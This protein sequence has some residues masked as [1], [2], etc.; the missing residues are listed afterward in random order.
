MP[1]ENALRCLFYLSL[2]LAYFAFS[3]SL[4]KLS[5]WLF[6][7]ITTTTAVL[8]ACWS[9]R[10][11][12]LCPSMTSL[13]RRYAELKYNDKIGERTQAAVASLNGLFSPC[14]EDPKLTD[15]VL[16]GQSVDWLYTVYA[17]IYISQN[18]VIGHAT[19]VAFIDFYVELKLYLTLLSKTYL[20]LDRPDA[21]NIVIF[22]DEVPY[23]RQKFE[24]LKLYQTAQSLPDPK[25]GEISLLS[26][27]NRANAAII[28]YEDIL[29]P[30]A[31]LRA[32]SRFTLL[33]ELG[34]K[35]HD[36]ITGL[37]D[38]R[39]NGCRITRVLGSQQPTF[40][41]FHVLKSMMMFQFLGK[42]EK[43]PVPKYFPN[44]DSLLDC[45][46]V[47]NIEILEEAE[48]SQKRIS[49][50][51]PKG[52]D[53]LGLLSMLHGTNIFEVLYGQGYEERFSRHPM[54]MMFN[55]NAECYEFKMAYQDDVAHYVQTG[56]N[57]Y[58]FNYAEVCD[59]TGDTVLSSTFHDARHLADSLIQRFSTNFPNSTGFTLGFHGTS[60]GGMY[61]IKTATHVASVHPRSLLSFALFQKTFG[62]LYN[63]AW[64]RMGWIGQVFSI[65]FGSSVDVYEDYTSLDIP[66]TAV[67]DVND[68]IIP[69]NLSLSAHVAHR[70]MKDN[71]GDFAKAFYEVAALYRNSEMALVR[72]NEADRVYAAFYAL[73]S[74]GIHLGVQ[75]ALVRDDWHKDKTYLAL[76]LARMVTF[77]SL[78]ANPTVTMRP[79]PLRIRHLWM[80]LSQCRVGGFV[81]GE[82][83]A[84]RYLEMPS[85]IALLFNMFFK[86]RAALNVKTPLQ[87]TAVTRE[88]PTYVPA[89]PDG[90]PGWKVVEP[91]ADDDQ[92]A[93]RYFVFWPRNKSR[94]TANI[95]DCTS[96]TA[97]KVLQ[98]DLAFFEL[99]TTPLDGVQVYAWMQLYTL[100]HTVAL[101]HTLKECSDAE[102]QALI[103]VGAFVESVMRHAFDEGNSAP[104]VKAPAL[105]NGPHADDVAFFSNR[106]RIFGNVLTT[107]TSHEIL[108]DEGDRKL[109]AHFFT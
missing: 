35:L 76:F 92:S 99:D 37:T 47:P 18:A 51:S 90:T 12:S 7:L 59:S 100:L 69:S 81:A 25:N 80:M 93:L 44:R 5:K 106:Y 20:K 38:R 49:D 83:Y 17:G 9:V 77:G 50:F 6:Y 74:A 1:Y 2:F 95:T 73:N 66:K 55:N 67:F 68:L 88:T 56:R 64:F 57:V 14:A 98:E 71:Y 4:Y 94:F 79:W 62:S 32:S 42:W 36:S 101:L 39:K 82:Q 40:G 89:A 3:F 72:S 102:P 104:V 60:I 63:M 8:L 33:R 21:V 45:M 24:G 43:V 53:L 109:L 103:K 65:F 86:G 105:V 29:A 26:A 48:K 22:P 34:V 54:V 30:F 78:P 16:L 11:F 19:P 91:T 10:L 87:N 97:L 108:L 13:G 41:S 58:L 52:K 61:A 70:Y 107:F 23:H 96:D 31:A 27:L 15:L 84:H 28:S 46:L 75:D 85:R